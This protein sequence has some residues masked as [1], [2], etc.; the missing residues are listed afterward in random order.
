MNTKRFS[1]PCIWLV[2]FAEHGDHFEKY[3]FKS[4][5]V[6]STINT[7]IAGKD[8]RHTEFL[9]CH[10]FGNNGLQQQETVKLSLPKEKSTDLI[11]SQA[12][13]SLIIRDRTDSSGCEKN[14]HNSILTQIIINISRVSKG[15][16]LPI[17]KTGQTPERLYNLKIVPIVNTRRA[18]CGQSEY[19]PD[20][21]FWTW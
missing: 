3:L 19:I 13:Q 8:D 14:T 2:T 11:W 1:L 20:W 10:F 17:M 15:A 9:N 16:V 7:D 5:I 18:K 21:V 12:L 6:L 4:K